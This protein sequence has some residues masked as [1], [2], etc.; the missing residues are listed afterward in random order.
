LAEKKRQEKDKIHENAADYEAISEAVLSR[1]KER[2]D[3][4]GTGNSSSDSEKE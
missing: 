3:A 2:Q 4:Q 1:E